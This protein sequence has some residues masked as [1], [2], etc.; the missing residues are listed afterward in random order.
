[1]ASGISSCKYSK[2]CMSLQDIVSGYVR[3]T[4]KSW[5]VF[6]ELKYHL[7]KFTLDEARMDAL[8]LFS[9]EENWK[10]EG[11][12]WCLYTDVAVRS[13]VVFLLWKSRQC[14]AN[15]KHFYDICTTST[16]RLRRRSNIVQ[17][18]YKCFLFAGWIPS[19]FRA[20]EHIT[21]HFTQLTVNL[22]N[23]QLVM[24]LAMICSL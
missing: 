12:L 6:L 15:A 17:M 3:V 2:P 20:I 16:Q 23:C 10:I 24:R 9:F 8:S 5:I 1:M 7:Y 14:P 13:D 22:V 11:K 18:L 19:L 21:S 4:N